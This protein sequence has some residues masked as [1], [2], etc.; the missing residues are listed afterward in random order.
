VRAGV[1]VEVAPQM[2]YL[3]LADFVKH[4]AQGQIKQNLRTLRQRVPGAEKPRDPNVIIPDP[5]SK[6]DM[7]YRDTVEQ[8]TTYTNGERS[9]TL[10]EDLIGNIPLQRQ[11]NGTLLDEKYLWEADKFK[12]D[13]ATKLTDALAPFGG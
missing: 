13:P 5:Q 8:T 7:I 10:V 2:A 12:Y 3:T 6:I 11:I 9:L 1:V 4:L